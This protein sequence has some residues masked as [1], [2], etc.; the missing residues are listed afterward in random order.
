MHNPRKIGIGN[1]G[2]TRSMYSSSKYLNLE[3][4]FRRK[5]RFNK[6][7]FNACQNLSSSLSLHACMRKLLALKPWENS[8]LHNSIFRRTWEHNCLAIFSMIYKGFA[9]K[10]DSM[11]SLQFKIT[12]HVVVRHGPVKELRKYLA[13]N[14][15]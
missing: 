12:K 8:L 2:N 1:Q 11:L 15:V 3:S 14:V 5:I 7:R 6:F 9:Q 10:W 4:E 13:F